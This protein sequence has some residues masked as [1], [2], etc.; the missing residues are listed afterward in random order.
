MARLDAYV[1][2]EWTLVQMSISKAFKE[3]LMDIR[4]DDADGI[5]IYQPRYLCFT[6]SG[7]ITIVVDPDSLK[8]L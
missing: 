2:Y 7:G 6:S 4:I 1:T 3:G 8:F 5:C